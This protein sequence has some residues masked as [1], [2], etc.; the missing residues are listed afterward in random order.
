VIDT[1]LDHPAVLALC[2]SL[3]LGLALVVTQ[4]GLRYVRPSE[5]ILVSIP[6]VTA[7]VWLSVLIVGLEGFDVRAAAVFFAIGLFYPAAVTMLTYQANHLMGPA[8]AGALGSLAPLFAVLGGILLFGEWPAPLQTFGILTI[9]LGVVLLSV[10]RGDLTRAWPLWAIALPLA[11]S[12]LRGTAQPITKI[13][14]AI[15][16][17]SFAAVVLGYTAATLVVAIVGLAQHRHARLNL[18]PK[19]IFWFACVGISN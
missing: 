19:G 10:S 2:A 7:I 17:S 15:W 8:V 13:G 1:L 3:F 11:A 6:L 16:P 5:G 12:V 14:L 9:V 18:P 4:F